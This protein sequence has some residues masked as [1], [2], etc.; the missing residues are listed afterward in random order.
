MKCASK[1][2]LDREGSMQKDFK[3][4]RRL[5][6]YDQYS[7]NIENEV[8]RSEEDRYVG[9]ERALEVL[10]PVKEFELYPVDNINGFKE[11]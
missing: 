2:A 4:W 3:V 11:E 7:W 6:M 8:E 1:V 5:E 10:C 9:Q